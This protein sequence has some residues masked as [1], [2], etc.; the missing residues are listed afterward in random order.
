MSV[1]R[2]ARRVSAAALL[3]SVT[4]ASSIGCG[5]SVEGGVNGLDVTLTPSISCTQTGLAPRSC[6]DAGTLAQQTTAARWTLEVGKDGNSAALTLHDGRVLTGLIFNDD[7]SLLE[8]AECDGTGGRCVFVR[9]RESSSDINTG[10]ATA[11]ELYVVGRFDPDEPTR[12]DGT[13]NA[14]TAASELCGTPARTENQSTFT[15]TLTEYA[16]L[17]TEEAQP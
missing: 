16:V 2:A 9:R 3:A 7:L 12:F 10:C 5:A 13:F 6:V 8:S 15:A 1:V 14:V 11:D 17:A 4:A